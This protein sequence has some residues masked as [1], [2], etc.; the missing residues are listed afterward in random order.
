MGISA[1]WSSPKFAVVVLLIWLSFLVFL[2]CRYKLFANEKKF[3]RFGPAPE[4]EEPIKLFGIKIDTMKKVIIIMVY[5]FFS[6]I[7]SDYGKN[8]IN[9]WI[10]NEIQNNLVT[11]LSVSKFWVFVISNG[12]HIFGWMNYII[13]LFMI[14]TMELQF[15]IP[16]MIA[17]F[18]VNNITTWNYIASK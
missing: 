6:T 7:V 2:A 13:Q 16:E 9:P 3:F 4:G 15:M 10:T 18:L 1:N 14:F 12:Y 5:S 8:I 17:S 11:S